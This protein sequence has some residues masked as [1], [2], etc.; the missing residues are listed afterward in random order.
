MRKSHTSHRKT[1]RL[2]WAETIP[3]GKTP[4]QLGKAQP[5]EAAEHSRRRNFQRRKFPRHPME[6]SEGASAEPNLN[7][8]HQ[9]DQS[10][11][12]SNTETLSAARLTF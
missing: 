12:I 5:P 4:E 6:G 10:T 1:H 11:M 9:W 8:G 7:S 3:L 2:V